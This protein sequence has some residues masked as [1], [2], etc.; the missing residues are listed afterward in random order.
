[1]EAPVSNIQGLSEEAI[2]ALVLEV[3]SCMTILANWDA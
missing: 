1:V 3:D 2:N